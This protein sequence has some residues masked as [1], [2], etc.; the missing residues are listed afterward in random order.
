[1]K[2]HNILENQINKFLTD[3]FRKDD[4]MNVFLE[5]ISKCYESF[6][7][8]KKITEHAF[9][10]SE[11]EYQ[12]VTQDLHEQNE[13][14][15]KSIQKLKEAIRSL[16]PTG[17]IQFTDED[18]DLIHIIT[19]LEK[20]ITKT[21]QLEQDLIKSKD[22]AEKA[23]QAKSE[24]LSVMSHEIRTPL[25]AIIGTIMLLQYHELLPEQ[26]ELLNV[27]EI[28]SENLLSLIN[29]V[30]DFSKL[31]EGNIFFVERNINILQFLKN[32]KMANRVRAEEK[33][34]AIKILFDDDI[35]KFVVGDDV[36]LGQILNN[37]VSN[38]VK[39]TH[40]GTITIRVGLHT[41]N[42]TD[43]EIDFS[44][45]DN[46]IGIPPEKQELVF[47]RFTQANN[48][49]TREFGGS[50]LGLT[51]IKRLL[52]LQDS[53]IQLESEA[54]KGSRFYFRLGFKRNSTEEVH[55]AKPVFGLKKMDMSGL[56]ILLVEDVAFNVMVAEKMLQNWNAVVDLANNGAIAVDKIRDN[57][58]DLVLMDIQMPVMDGYTATTEIRKFNQDIPIIALTASTINLDIESQARKS[59]M[60][61]CITKPF[62]P[63]DLYSIIMEKAGK[64]E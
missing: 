30:L 11:R 14:R 45:E 44:I 8:D 7:K 60:N 26:K 19:F 41:I 56:K 40:N 21:K 57:Q 54:G 13:I 16:D 15:K 27:M 42:E 22:I 32:I 6:E 5:T 50:G 59:G 61:G 47:E 10:V 3:K 1:M 36:R 52:E 62:N 49:I 12:I 37:L 34:N 4:E 29:D 33:G 24:F 48:N 17:P 55:E 18:D 39:F 23:A 51:I 31:E 63:G 28:S 58:Y 35:P 38:A 43:V 53:R 25:N 20:Q 2:Y 64:N 46:G 9:D